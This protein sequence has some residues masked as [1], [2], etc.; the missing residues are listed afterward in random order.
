MSWRE[1]VFLGFEKNNNTGF[2]SVFVGR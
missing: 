2:E 1:R